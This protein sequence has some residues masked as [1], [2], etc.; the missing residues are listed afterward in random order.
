MKKSLLSTLFLFLVIIFASNAQILV[1]VKWSFESK[2]INNEEFDLLLTATIDN[3]WHIYGVEALDGGPIPT[4]FKFNPGAEYELVGKMELPAAHTEYDEMF[5]MNVSSFSGICVFK[6]RVKVKSAVSFSITGETEHQA[7]NDRAC[8]APEITEFSFNLPGMKAAVTQ[9]AS[10]PAKTVAASDVPKEQP[11]EAPAEIKTEPVT[12]I[13]ADKTPLSNENVAAT[14]P[15][16][17]NAKKESDSLWSFFF[18]AMGIGFIG[19]LTPCVYPMIPMTVTFFMNASQNK[20]KAKSQAVFFGISIIFI[21]TVIGILVSVLFGADTIKQ[22]SENWIT[23]IIFF[24]LFAFFA[25]SFFGMFEL[26][27]PAWLTNKSDAQADRGG[28]VGAFF[29][30]LTLVLVSFSCT[31]PFVGGIL[32]EAATGQVLMPTIGMFGFSL[33]FGIVFTILA[34]FPSWLNKMPKSGGWLNSVKVVL[35]FLILAIGSK[36]LNVP[37]QALGWGL[38][39]EV[40]IAFWITLFVLLGL[41]LMGKIRFSHDSPVEHI[42]VPRLLLVIISFTFAIYLVPGMF[43]AP[44]KA[45]S[46]Y[47]PSESAWDLD[48]IIRE[49]TRNISVAGPGSS[50]PAGLCDEPKYADR[51]ELPHGLKGYFDYEQGMACAK[52]LNKPVFLDVKGHAC[53]NCK[54]M[55]K[56]VWSD[57]EVIKRLQNDYVIIALYVDDNY[58]LPENEWI[59]S[60]FDGKVKKTIGRKNTD[61][62]ITRFG[63]NAQPYYVL[64]DNNGKELVQ[65]IGFEPSVEKYVQFLDKG[66]EAYKKLKQ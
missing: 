21:Y 43:G 51:F 31:A 10:E 5:E 46:G 15:E 4:S 3:G 26:V 2:Q 7:C 64:M 49:S 42:A 41:Y 63:V 13:Q 19:L 12:T 50:V 24:L 34:L 14:E 56:N 30:A 40:F 65:S 55:E 52:K 39:R 8:I 38:T 27:L 28:Y 48:E 44:L 54:V 22:V 59:T 47:L 53:T 32:V 33:A 60:T 11:K 23:N 16:D 45:V 1:P 17:E 57:P 66:V 36:Y 62:Q 18:L 58:E 35:A 29:M 9:P 20:I 61:F 37:N 25:A 6:Q